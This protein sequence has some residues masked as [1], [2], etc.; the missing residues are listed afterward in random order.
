MRR[1]LTLEEISA[2]FNLELVGPYH[3]IAVSSV[4]SVQQGDA[5]SISYIDSKKYISQLE[6][7]SVAAVLISEA[8]RDEK[9][10][11]PRLISKNPALDISAIAGCFTTDKPSVAYRA[12]S[13]VVSKQAYIGK[14]VSIASGVVIEAG[15]IIGNNVTIM[16]NAVIKQDS[17]IFDDC[18]I[19]PAAVISH[20]TIHAGTTIYPHASIGFDG[21]G[22]K[23]NQQQWKKTPHWGSVVIGRNC[24]IGAS[25]NIDR[26]TYGNTI[27][28]EGV[29][30]D[31]HCHIGHNVTIGNNVLMAGFSAVAG[32]TRIGDR[33]TIG[34]RVAMADHLTIVPDVTVLFG[35]TVSASIKQA[36]EYS[37]HIPAQPHWQWKKR[38][39]RFLKDK[40]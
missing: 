4:S 36:G 11:K 38:L 17:I 35:S 40:I 1:F 21:F 32:S 3:D 19:H 24:R 39:V 22:Y 20:A 30:I 25:C 8:L 13:A 26:G 34:G 29:K 6:K 18:T 7:S 37:G 16:E 28:G 27:L 33:C 15:V 12:P 31:A 2:Q 10:E 14:K 9:I 5:S 23:R